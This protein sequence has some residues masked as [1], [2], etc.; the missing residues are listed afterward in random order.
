[1]LANI[2]TTVDSPGLTDARPALPPNSQLAASSPTAPVALGEEI[3]MECHPHYV[4]DFGLQTLMCGN[5][6]LGTSQWLAPDGSAARPEISCSLNRSWCPELPS[7]TNAH[8]VHMM[9][10]HRAVDTEVQLACRRGY[11]PT[12]GHA[13]GRC[14]VDGW[15]SMEDAH[16]A[17]CTSPPDWLRCAPWP[18]NAHVDL[19]PAY[20]PAWPGYDFSEPYNSSRWTAENVIPQP[21]VPETQKQEDLPEGK[22]PP[23]RVPPTQKPPTEQTGALKRNGNLDRAYLPN[24]NSRH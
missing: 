19:I 16:S 5:S 24:C 22:D 13:F 14:S 7:L 4:Y 23:K 12:A 2:M 6:A 15:C 11:Q 10:L 8:V 20:C 18:K 3:S 1:M 17:T 9:P 21:A